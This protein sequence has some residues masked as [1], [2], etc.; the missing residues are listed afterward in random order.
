MD[1]S[2]LQP[3]PTVAAPSSSLSSAASDAKRAQIDKSAK[4]LESSFLSV[5]FGQMFDGTEVEAP[6]GGGQA[7]NTFRSFLTDAMAKQVSGR[8][9]IGLSGA[10]SREMLK[11]QGMS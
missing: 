11:M 5:M 8:G 4:A 2:A 6:F 9:G 3:F 1:T 7:E 10:I